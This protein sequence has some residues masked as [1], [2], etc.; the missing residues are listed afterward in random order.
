MLAGSDP[1]RSRTIILDD[2]ATWR[3]HGERGE[4]VQAQRGH[5]LR[6]LALHLRARCLHLP[7]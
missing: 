3:E 6:I 1:G 2:A 5:Y 7:A 4:G